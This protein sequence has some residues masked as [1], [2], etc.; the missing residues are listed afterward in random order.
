MLL[1]MD[2]VGRDQTHTYI[3]VGARTELNPFAP[4]P[5]MVCFS[6]LLG[7]SLFFAIPSFAASFS[8]RAADPCAKIAGQ[9]YSAPADALACLRQE[10]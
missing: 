3:V 10:R 4:F 6:S 8:E 2:H 7:A 5:T 1:L 9:Q